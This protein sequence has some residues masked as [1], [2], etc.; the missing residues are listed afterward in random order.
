MA[1]RSS[2]RWPFVAC[3]VLQTVIFGSGSAI[4]K[5]AYESITP[6]WCLVVRFGLAALVFAIFLGPRIV[7]QLRLVRVRDWLPAA[8]CMALSFIACNVALDL[9]TAT[10]VGFLVALPVVFAPLLSSIVNRRRYPFSFL[11]FQGAVVAGLYLLCANGGAPSFGWGEVFA[12]LSSMTMAGALVFGEHGLEKLDAATIAGTQVGASF[13]ISLLCALAFEQPMDV[14]SVQPMA[15]GVV[16][17]LA[18]LST[19]LTFFLQNLALTS[20][21][22]STVSLLLTGEPVFTALF[23]F[24]I[25]GETLSATGLVGAAV[26]VAGVAAA[27]WMEGRRASDADDGFADGP[28]PDAH[29]AAASKA[30]EMSQVA[31]PLSERCP[32]ASDRAV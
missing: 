11:P 21:P 6:L 32:L 29:K 20:L 7:R 5:I 4:T 16:V 26:I 18:L 1:R 28:S 19:C 8:V 15:W 12:L 31:L 27:T 22:S 17:F 24:V 2:A 13:A 3:V 25:L 23:S 14:A 10:N 30:V 9:T